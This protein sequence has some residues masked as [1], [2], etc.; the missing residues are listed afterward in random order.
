MYL[1]DIVQLVEY[2]PTV[3]EAQGWINKA[4][5]PVSV[6]SALREVEAGGTEVIILRHL[7]V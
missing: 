2:L 7:G 6:I 1:G 3:Q 4:R 5:R